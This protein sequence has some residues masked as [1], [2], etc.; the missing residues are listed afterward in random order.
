MLEKA[1]LL[2]KEKVVEDRMRWIWENPYKS[3]EVDL[4]E[5]A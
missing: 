5:D 3:D 1:L 2:T 4:G